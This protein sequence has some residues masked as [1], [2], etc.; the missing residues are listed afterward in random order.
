MKVFSIFLFSLL[1][2]AVAFAPSPQA[3]SAVSTSLAMGWFDT[4]GG[5][6]QKGKKK[7]DDWIK[8]MFLKPVHGG[9]SAKEKDLDDIYAAQQQILANRRKHMDQNT[10]RSK[11]K[12]YGKDHL[13]EIHTIAHDPKALNKREDDAM[14]I[15]KD[16]DKKTSFFSWNKK[17]K[18]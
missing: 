16:H 6:K 15:D 1:S 18:P 3:R 17:L 8:N 10:L 2:T 7:S 5:S 4:A 9:G 14:Y 12:A 11:Y 13:R